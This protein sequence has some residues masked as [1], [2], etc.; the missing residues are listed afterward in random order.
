MKRPLAAA[1]SLRRRSSVLETFIVVAALISPLAKA[2]SE[3]PAE[4]LI[5]LTVDPMPAPK[6]ALRYMLL[7]DLRE[8]TSGNPIPN[9]LKCIL[10]QDFSTPTEELGKAALK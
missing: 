8:Q 3:P 1:H 5:K 9:Y 4:T 7:P 2:Q 10:D 6:P